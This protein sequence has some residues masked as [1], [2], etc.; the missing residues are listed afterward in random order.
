MLFSLSPLLLQCSLTASRFLFCPFSLCSPGLTSLSLSLSHV[1]ARLF[2]LLSSQLIAVVIKSAALCVAVWVLVAKY[3]S[4]L[5][6]NSSKQQQQQQQRQRPGTSAAASSEAPPPTPT[7]SAQTIA[8]IQ[9]CPD[10]DPYRMLCVHREATQIE[11]R[12]A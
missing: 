1:L 8:W 12:K 6:S 3:G 5:L 7:T 11:I 9:K 10:N 4:A 2:T